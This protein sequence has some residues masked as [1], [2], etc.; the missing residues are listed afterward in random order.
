MGRLEVQL[1]E[2]LEDEV[3]DRV[4]ETGLSKSEITRAALVRHL[5]V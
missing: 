4:D 3:E 2:E 5:G 1:P